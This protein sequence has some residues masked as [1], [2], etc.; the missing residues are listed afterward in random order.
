[1]ANKTGAPDKP[2]SARTFREQA[3]AEEILWEAHSSKH[4]V[5]D[6]FD[7]TVA[8]MRR[9]IEA[10][11]ND[12]A[13]ARRE[14]YAREVEAHPKHWSHERASVKSAVDA[15]YGL[16]RDGKKDSWYRH[17]FPAPPK[18]KK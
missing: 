14:E 13:V 3:L 2:R 9:E 6:V 4:D 11:S 5:W 17:H 7:E 15:W 8:R 10:L 1:M 12:D 18:N 16:F